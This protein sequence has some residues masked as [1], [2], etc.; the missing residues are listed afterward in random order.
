M[1]Q[2]QLGYEMAGGE[3]LQYSGKLT[4]RDLRPRPRSRSVSI[5]RRPK[6]G[7]IGNVEGEV[8]AISRVDFAA[9]K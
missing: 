3:W 8:E 2:V 9:E 7:G 6:L 5:V 1:S 4:C